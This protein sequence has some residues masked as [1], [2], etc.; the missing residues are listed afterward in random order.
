MNPQGVPRGRVSGFWNSLLVSPRGVQAC[1]LTSRGFPC[2]GQPPRS[3]P[4]PYRKHIPPAQTNP[5]PLKKSTQAPARSAFHPTVG[6]PPNRYKITGVTADDERN[7]NA[8]TT[9]RH[10]HAI[11][12]RTGEARD[13]DPRACT[14][15]HTQEQCGN[16]S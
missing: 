8:V 6:F 9:R 11:T 12:D 13:T 3:T 14:N 15:G 4:P 10:R 7:G 1:I 2:N 5:T 16:T